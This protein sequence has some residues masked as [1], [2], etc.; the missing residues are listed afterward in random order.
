LLEVGGS[1]SIQVALRATTLRVAGLVSAVANLRFAVM[2][3]AG[4]QANFDRLG[5]ITRVDLRLK[6]GVDVDAF[7]QR[8]QQE[9]PAGLAVQHP[10]ASVKASETL[11]RSYRVN[12]N[13][14]AL[15]AL[16]TGGLL[17]FSTQALAVVRRRAQL[18]LLRVLG[19]TR[20]QLVMWL[21]AE[22]ALVGIAGSALGLAGGFILAQAALRIIGADLGAGYFRGVARR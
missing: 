7:R 2:D 16:F 19:V 15:V 13:I 20:R 3:I 21:V 1:L 22:G 17:V 4:A 14:L 9:L 11:S 12:L 18:A 6:P 8:L 10:E 5:R